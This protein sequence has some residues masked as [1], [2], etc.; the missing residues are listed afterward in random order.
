MRVIIERPAG[1]TAKEMKAITGKI[2]SAI[3]KSEPFKQL[4]KDGLVSLTVSEEGKV[5]TRAQTEARRR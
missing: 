5:P 4:K 2:F 3:N 1:T